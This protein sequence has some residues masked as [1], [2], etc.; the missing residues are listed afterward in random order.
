MP[1]ALLIVLDVGK[2]DVEYC[3]TDDAR[4][5]AGL[6]LVWPSV[7][8]YDAMV[9]GE[10]GSYS[11]LIGGVKNGCMKSNEDGLW[12]NVECDQDTTSFTSAVCV[13]RNCIEPTE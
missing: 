7:G 3:K 10:I 8:E 4:Y 6:G 2:D 12:V 1:N 5:G 9:T 11:R 13:K